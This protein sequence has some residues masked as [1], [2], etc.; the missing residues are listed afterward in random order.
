MSSCGSAPIG[1]CLQLRRC[2]VVATGGYDEDDAEGKV[3]FS[4]EL[5]G[6]HNVVVERLLSIKPDS[7]LRLYAKLGAQFRKERLQLFDIH[8]LPEVPYVLAT[9]DIA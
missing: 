4:K 5:F 7:T 6:A 3:D 9:R 2:A 8:L 1:E